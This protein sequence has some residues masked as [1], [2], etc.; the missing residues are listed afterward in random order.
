[1]ALIGEVIREPRIQLIAAVYSILKLTRY[2]FLFWLPLYMTE[3]LHY[4]T[5]DAGYS[6]AAFEVAGFF[7]VL[8]AGY[9]SDKWFHSKRFPTAAIMMGLLAA[10]CL[11]YPALSA[12]SGLANVF[13]IAL[14]G[15][16]IFGPDTL[17]GGAAAQ[18]AAPAG[19]LATAAG[20]INGTGSIGQLISP[21]LVVLVVQE[22]GWSNL[23][24]FFASLASGGAIL[25]SVTR[26]ERTE[27]LA[28]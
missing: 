5:A 9:V 8:A 10:V 1:M 21:W 13:G 3:E 6:S 22:F 2:S 12:W 26:R 16:M 24:Y 20:F 28:T 27:V 18:D 23:F 25:L 15:I 7:G 11:L 17:L 4:S 14:I 19:A